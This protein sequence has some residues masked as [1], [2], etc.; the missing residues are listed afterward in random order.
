[1]A[2]VS[3]PVAVV[4]AEDQWALVR[5]V[6]VGRTV[7]DAA[8]EPF[9]PFC[10]GVQREGALEE[11]VVQQSALRVE[12]AVDDALDEAVSVAGVGRH[13]GVEQRP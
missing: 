10:R 7:G 11:D 5:L 3:P 1:M 13:G 6:V 2:N 12:A 4:G 8:G 9:P